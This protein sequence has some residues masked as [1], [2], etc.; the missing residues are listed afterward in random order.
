MRLGWELAPVLVPSRLFALMT[1]AG[2]Q[3]A[4]RQPSQSRPKSSGR[5]VPDLGSQAV[6]RSSWMQLGAGG[7]YHP[8]G[9]TR[10]IQTSFLAC[11]ANS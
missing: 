6:G 8:K 4:K 11:I 7:K 9:A 10:H 3:D 1:E 2:R 5:L